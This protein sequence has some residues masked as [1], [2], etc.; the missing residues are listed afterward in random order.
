IVQIMKET[1][2]LMIEAGSHTDSRGPKAYN[3][4]LSERRAKSTVDYIVSK[5]ISKDRIIAKGYGESQLINN[6][7]DGVRCGIE[8]HK[9]NRR[10]EFIITNKQALNLPKEQKE[11]VKNKKEINVI[12]TPKITS[13]PAKSSVKEGTSNDSSKGEIIFLK[14]EE[15]KET[16]EAP[17]EDTSESAEQDIEKISVLNSDQPKIEKNDIQRNNV[18][19]NSET[20]QDE[21]GYTKTKKDPKELS[22]AAPKVRGKKYG[23]ALLVDNGNQSVK[24]II[25]ESLS[26][27][28][29]V[30]TDVA[31]VN[32]EKI[33]P[34]ILEEEAPISAQISAQPTTAILSE[35]KLTIKPTLKSDFSVSNESVS[36]KNI[37]LENESIAYNKFNKDFTAEGE[38]MKTVSNSL[39]SD[40]DDFES[41]DDKAITSNRFTSKVKRDKKIKTVSIAKKTEELKE[42]FIESTKGMKKEEVLSIQGIDIS[43]MAIRKNGKYIA[44]K[45]A[46][47]VDVMRINFQIANNQ[48]ITP[49]YK[50]VF[51]LIQ[52]PEGKILNRKG[53][54]IV[55]N[56][57]T[58]TYT[59]KTNA[60]YNNNFLNLSMMTDRFIQRIIKG[61]YTVTIYIEGYPVGLEM[62]TLS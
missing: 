45:A 46:N 33:E 21:I 2:V 17:H 18:H 36:E 35:Q 28:N 42:Q 1:P 31:D 13:A 32:S 39:F 16:E 55:N 44:T 3:Q 26:E 4:K 19:A 56:G 57:E 15:K 52:N 10:T 7:K 59:E 20:T 37:V 49:G 29:M 43:P 47:K 60:Y 54:F 41:F 61:T 9:L 23:K 27:N 48:E 25:P 38:N 8:K 62:F 14:D 40:D 24:K 11:S 12:S 34:D 53:E 30:S 6:C 5:G 50:E 58:L 22:T 51:I